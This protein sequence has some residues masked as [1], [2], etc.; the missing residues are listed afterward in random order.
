MRERT[1][2]YQ[3]IVSIKVVGLAMAILLAGCLLPS[4]KIWAAN[5]A[6]AQEP[7]KPVQPQAAPPKTAMPGQGATKKT[8]PVARSYDRTLLR[9]ALLKEKA[10]ETYQ[11][12]FTTTRGDF[13]ITV[14]RAWAPLGA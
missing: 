6:A 14:T 7:V 2:A 13:V 5:Q 12:K 4:E 8:A 11:V 9:P 1:A 3:K 10:P